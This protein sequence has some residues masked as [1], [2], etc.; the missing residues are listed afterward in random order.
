MFGAG[1]DP[2]DEV[3]R[4]MV[5]IGLLE[6]SRPV[7][8]GPKCG[9]ALGLSIERLSISWSVVTGAR[10]HES[11]SGLLPAPVSPIPTN[12]DPEPP[13]M[14][15]E[16]LAGHLKEAMELAAG[17]TARRDL[18]GVGVA[19]PAVIDET[20][21]PS[22]TS[23]EAAM[24]HSALEA[25]IDDAV[26]SAGFHPADG[27]RLVVSFINDADSDL[28]HEVRWGCA[29]GRRDVL[30]I[31]ICGRIGGAILQDGRLVR[32]ARGAAGEIG[33]LP[34]DTTA[35]PRV[36]DYDG[37]PALDDLAPCDCTAASCVAHFASGRAIIDTID[38]LGR[39]G[40]SYN[41]RGI[42]IQR[43]AISTG[44]RSRKHK[45]I[46][47]RAGQ[48]V[49][50][51]VRVPVLVLD[52]ECI[53][54]TAF[55]GHENLAKGVYRGLGSATEMELQ[56]IIFSG[57]LP[58]RTAAGAARL[59]VEERIIPVVDEMT[60]A[61]EVLRPFKLP[62]EMRQNLDGPVD[63]VRKYYRPYRCAPRGK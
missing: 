35:L 27:E 36:Q 14:S 50:T 20:G 61:S 63:D 28:L 26:R 23:H 12:E 24:T 17:Q 49:G 53:V 54:L 18:A 32:G 33:H 52:P 16:H 2:P 25:A 29:V 43:E 8:F 42:R 55:P 5:E 4:H 59:I 30:G 19:W 7:T 47:E 40:Q 57:P 10:P 3:W 46:F 11:L 9:V 60:G 37:I 31:K 58:H 51:A 34:V 21:V 45:E 62:W 1:A 39:T 38:G 22:I 41:E 44:A 56:D 6:E 15:L 13:M 48:I